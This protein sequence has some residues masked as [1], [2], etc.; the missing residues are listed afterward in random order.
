MEGMVNDLQLARDNQQAFEEWC[1]GQANS[2]SERPLPN[3]QY[4]SP[5]SSPQGTSD[6]LSR[7][8]ICCWHHRT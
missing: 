3:P 8:A 1:Q 5:P 4:T 6:R 2:G 7:N